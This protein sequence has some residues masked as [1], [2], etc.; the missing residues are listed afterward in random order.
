MAARADAR[1]PRRDDRARWR[2]QASSARERVRGGGRSSGAHPP[3]IVAMLSGI[4]SCS[5]KPPSSVKS[6]TSTAPPPIPAADAITTAQKMA[7][8]QASS[9][10]PSG[11]RSRWCVLLRNRL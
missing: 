1:A 11:K 9:Q 8:V 6:G 7:A 4:A 2:R 10:R 5:V 3:K